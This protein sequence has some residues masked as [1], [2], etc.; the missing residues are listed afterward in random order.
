LSDFG[1]V[2]SGA[3]LSSVKASKKSKSETLMRS[4]MRHD[5]I[6]S[7]CFESFT[8]DALIKRDKVKR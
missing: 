2:A 6:E 4:A 3:T 5:V 8:S 1:R 7:V